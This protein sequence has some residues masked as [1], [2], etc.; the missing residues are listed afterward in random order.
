MWLAIQKLGVSK[1]VAQT[2][3][4]GATIRLDQQLTI[5]DGVSGLVQDLSNSCWGY[6]TATHSNGTTYTG[7]TNAQGEY[8]LSSLELGDFTI[9]ATKT[10]YSSGEDER[11]TLSADETELTE[12][13]VDGMVLNNAEI[14]GTVVQAVTNAGIKGAEISLI[15]REGNV[16]SSTVSD[17]SGAYSI[18]GMSPGSFL[19]ITS[20]EGFER[21]TTGVF[22]NAGSGFQKIF[23][24]P[25]YWVACG[26][27]DR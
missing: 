10:G 17:E 8:G 21:D 27:S 20:K 24:C 23:S 1:E 26:E 18:S 25:Q 22:L 12:V 4:D 11:F 14:T 16:S 2:A 9:N 5:K 13:N 7:I 19:L 15:G 3:S 6:I